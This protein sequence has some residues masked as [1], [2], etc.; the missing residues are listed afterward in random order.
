MLHNDNVINTSVSEAVQK[1]PADEKKLSQML[2]YVFYFAQ[3]QLLQRVDQQTVEIVVYRLGF[4]Q[5]S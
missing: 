3:P 5:C 4:I 2:L 1:I